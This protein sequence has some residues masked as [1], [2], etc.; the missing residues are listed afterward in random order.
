MSTIQLRR[1]MK[2]QTKTEM[3]LKIAK[4]HKQIEKASICTNSKKSINQSGWQEPTR[5]NFRWFLL[6]NELMLA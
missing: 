2:T 1:K 4:L 6:Q 5:P 3:L